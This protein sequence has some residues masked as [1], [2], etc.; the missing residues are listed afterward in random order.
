MPG[1]F[2][3]A[4][5]IRG[6]VLLVSLCIA[7]GLFL[8][9]CHRRPYFPVCFVVAAMAAVVVIIDIMIIVIVVII[10]C[11]VVLITSSACFC[12][13]PFLLSMLFVLLLFVQRQ[14]PMPPTS[15]AGSS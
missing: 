8:Q 12:W 14:L 3:A 4:A 2:V 1:L 13:L 10:A 9:G 6:I 7:C 11:R 15:R 5:V